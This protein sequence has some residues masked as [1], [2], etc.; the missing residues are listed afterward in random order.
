MVNWRPHFGVPAQEHP[1]FLKSAA[2]QAVDHCGARGRAHV[3][4]VRAKRAEAFRKKEL[5]ADT[6]GRQITTVSGGTPDLMAR[7]NSR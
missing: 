1:F 4:L 2:I 6:A 5:A 7:R 3:C